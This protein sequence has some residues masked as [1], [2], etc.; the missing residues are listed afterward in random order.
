MSRISAGVASLGVV[1]LLACMGGDDSSVT[2]PTPPEADKAATDGDEAPKDGDKAGDDGDTTEG[3]WC[4]EYEGPLGATQALIDNP[5]ECTEKFGDK[6]AKFIKG[7]QCAPV[8]CKYAT[9][10][11]DLGKGY[12]YE[13][14]AAGNCTM[15]KGDAVDKDAEGSDAKDCVDPKGAEATTTDAPKPAPVAQPGPGRITRPGSGG[16]TGGGRGVLKPGGRGGKGGGRV[17]RPR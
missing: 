14:V 10:E 4:C 13:T 16:R 6:N 12:T 11:A 17:V 5:K 7:D 15:R 1:F 3:A 8:C 9:D 2:V